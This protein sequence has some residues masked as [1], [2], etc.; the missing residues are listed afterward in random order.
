MMHR[1]PSTVVFVSMMKLDPAIS[2]GASNRVA[3]ERITSSSHTGTSWT[4]GSGY[5]DDNVLATTGNDN[6]MLSMFSGITGN[7]NPTS[8]TMTSAV[9]RRMTSADV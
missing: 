7:S 2:T 8:Y 9:P 4:S 6:S 1:G 3:S 5:V